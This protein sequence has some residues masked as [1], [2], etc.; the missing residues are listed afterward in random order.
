MKTLVWASV[1]PFGLYCAPGGV[2]AVEVKEDASGRVILSNE[3]I[4]LAFNLKNGTYA[5]THKATGQ[6]VIDEAGL[7]ADCWGN[8]ADMHFKWIQEAVKDVFGEGR[9]L[10]LEMEH[11]GTRSV[12]VYLFSFTLYA[13]QGAIIMGFGLRNPLKNGVRLFK[14]VPLAHA[15]LFSGKPLDVPQT[16]NGAA[17]ADTPRVEAKSVRN[18]SN[19]LLLT[20][21]LGGERRSIV[22]GGLA[23]KEFG[24]W[25]E[26]KTSTLEMWAE[27]PVG[28]LVDPGQTYFSEDTFYL[29]VTQ[30]DPF[31]ALEQ[32]G[33]AMRAANQARPNVYDFPRL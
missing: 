16:L 28:R 33:L 9:R 19:S 4:S 3:A 25:V 6:V 1:V 10:V 17:G 21:T 13:H 11:G 31:V 32:Y 18:C 20:G 15:R 26:L 29:D 24:K 5:I 27:D 12:P 23:Y 7:S 2:A 30:Q 14:A 22:W 8:A